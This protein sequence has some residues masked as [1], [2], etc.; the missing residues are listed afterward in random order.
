MCQ[1]TYHV[2]FWGHLG[3]DMETH[4][5]HYTFPRLSIPPRKVRRQKDVPY[6]TL[7]IL[8]LRTPT[9]LMINILKIN[10]SL[11]RINL[12]DHRA[13]KQHPHSTRRLFSRRLQQHRLQQTREQER[14][15][16]IRRQLELIA[17]SGFRA[18]RRRHDASVV[19]EDIETLFASQERRC[20]GFDGAE[21]GEI[22]R[23][24]L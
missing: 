2:K 3:Q 11:G 18:L 6:L 13:R 12:R 4:S 5:K 1:T 20:A 14:P 16:A 23:E 9:L 8:K 24:E 19:P 15:E 21:V 10:P 7:P 22:Q 17:L